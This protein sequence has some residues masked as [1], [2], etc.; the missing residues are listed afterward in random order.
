MKLKR[1]PGTCFW[2]GD[3]RGPH[4]WKTCPANGKTC[5]KCGINDHFSRV[6]LEKGPPQQEHPRTTTQWQ[7]QGRGRGYRALHTHF[8]PIDS[9][10]LITL[11]F[12]DQKSADSVRKQLNDLRGKSLKI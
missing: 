10:V 7:A 1:E 3:R 12:K 11:P 2:C 8:K 9:P 4:P 6:C 5:T